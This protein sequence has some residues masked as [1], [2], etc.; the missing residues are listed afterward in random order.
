MLRKLGIAL[1]VLV[2]LAGA[3][4][5]WARR[6]LASAPAAPPELARVADPG[7]L[8]SLPGG[9]DV[10][11][12]TGRYGSHVW[13]GI[14]Y[15]LPPVGEQ[16][17]RAPQPRGAVERHARGARVRQSL[18]AVR[19]PLRRR[20]RRAGRRDERQR[21]LSLPERVRAR[22]GSR[23]GGA[24]EAARDGVDPRRRQRDRPRGLLRRRAH[25]ADPG[26][27][28]GDAQLPARTARLVPPRGAARRRVARRAVRQLRHAR[29][30]PRARV[31]A[32]RHRRVRR[33]SRAT[34]R[35]SASRRAAPT[36]TRCCS[37]RWRRGSSSAPSWRAAAPASARPPKRRTSTTPP[38]PV[39][40]ARRT[41]CWRD[42]SSRTARRPTPQ[43][44]GR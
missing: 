16:R 44:R 19:E 15:A 27:R 41:K 9:G 38:S 7:S 39:T 8:R 17:W 29:P 1:L 32:R 33:R 36:C 5:F 6:N 3:G 30:D 24:G 18:P 25:G 14:P 31:G 34:S 21:G 13:L 40:A 28:R 42:S 43:R 11:G 23:R 37:R 26:R 4:L 10:V 2:V 12:Y 22:A 35:S 20:R